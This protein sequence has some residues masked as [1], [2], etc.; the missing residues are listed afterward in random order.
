MSWK[1]ASDGTSKDKVN[2]DL[3]K[4]RVT[5]ERISTT[6]E[7]H[8]HEWIDTR[9]KTVKSGWRGPNFQKS[10]KEK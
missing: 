2:V 4:G 3:E 9:Q 6:G 8:E 7:K 10:E 1:K 5:H